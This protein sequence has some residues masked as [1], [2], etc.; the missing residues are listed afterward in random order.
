MSKTF[1]LMTATALLVGASAFAQSA[2]TQS[3]ANAPN[4]APVAGAPNAA[5]D[6]GAG[7][8]ATTPSNSAASDQSGSSGDSS[9]DMGMQKPHHRHHARMHGVSSTDNNAD[10]LNACMANALPTAEQEQC[11][12]QAANSDSSRSQ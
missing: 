8:D 5:P 1:A 4:S 6:A 9:S 11:L 2:N 10:K 12:R 7:N 3:P